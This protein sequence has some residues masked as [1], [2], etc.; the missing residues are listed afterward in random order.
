MPTGPTA[1]LFSAGLDSAVLAAAETRNG[2]V[3]PIYVSCGLP[4]LLAQTRALLDSGKFELTT[5]EAFALFPYTEHV[6]TL[7]VFDAVK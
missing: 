3:H 5:L 1:V 7:A 6:E 4:S 2:R